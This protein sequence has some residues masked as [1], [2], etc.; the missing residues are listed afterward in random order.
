MVILLFATRYFANT[1]KQRDWALHNTVPIPLFLT[2]T[3]ILDEE[4][5]AEEL[6]KIFARFIMERAEE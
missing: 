3:E 6:L 4:T 5:S 1:K 2:E